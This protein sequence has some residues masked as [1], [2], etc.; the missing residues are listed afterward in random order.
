[1]LFLN[2]WLLPGL[3]AVLIPIIIHL[4]NRRSAKFMDWGA[5]QF[6][7]DSFTSRKSRIQLEEVLLMAT[8]CLLMALLALAVARPF[9][10]AGSV[11]TWVVVLP[12]VLGGFGCMA[13]WSVLRDD[14]KW[15]KRM[16]W[17]GT[18]A[19]VLA[20]AMIAG[21]S[22]LGKRFGGADRDVVIILDSSASMGIKREGRTNFEHALEEARTLIKGSQPG[23][24]FGIVLAGGAAEPMF[25][26]PVLSRQD[27]IQRLERLEP[28]GGS[29]YLPQALEAAVACLSRGTR[30]PKQI[31]IISDAQSLNWDLTNMGAWMELRG[32]MRTLPVPPQVVW[33]R[34]P[35]PES[36]RNVAI[37]RV[38]FPK[39]S[40]GTYQDT[41]IDVT[42]RNT[43]RE[44][45]TPTSV[46]LGVA[47]Q[48][49]LMPAGGQL[50][51]GASSVVRF[52]HRFEM[53]G[54]QS[55]TARLAVEDDL[56]ADN[57]A[58]VVVPVA[59]N[60]HI[61]VVDGNPAAQL[62]DR[63]AG[64]A[65]LGLTPDQATTM[66]PLQEMDKTRFA[67][68]TTVVDAPA[69]LRIENF[70]PYHAVILSDVVRLPTQVV[71]RLTRYVESGGGLLVAPG[72]RSQPDFYNHWTSSSGPFLPAKLAQWSG[73]A[74]GMDRRAALDSF[75]MEA[76]KGLADTRFSDLD[77]W[78]IGPYWTLSETRGA[79]VT[80]DARMDDGGALLVERRLGQGRVLLTSFP[81]DNTGGN[82]VSRQ[83]FV[84]LLHSLVYELAEAAAPE[85][86]LECA[87]N[88]TL[89]FSPSLAGSPTAQKT[90]GLRGEYFDTTISASRPDS[91]RIDPVID[92]AWTNRP[93][94]TTVKRPS[95]VKPTVGIRWTGSLVP[96]KSGA[97]LFSFEG[98]KLAS[99][100]IEGNLILTGTRKR[101]M[102]FDLTAGKRCDI[103]IE[104]NGQNEKDKAQLLWT[105]PGATETVIPSACLL[106]T[107]GDAAIAEL[108]EQLTVMDPAGK[109]RDITAE[110]HN[111]VVGLTVSGRPVPGLYRV[112]TT[113]T[114][115]N[116]LGD[117]ID[118]EGNLPF[119]I[120]TGID[121]S[122]IAALPGPAIVMV[123][124]FV[125]LMEAPTTQDALL[126]LSGRRFGQELWRI[127]AWAALVLI[128]AEIG[129]ARWIAGSRRSGQW[130]RVAFDDT[131]AAAS[132]MG[133][134]P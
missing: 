15:R 87:P 34:L 14:P 55:I 93:A 86:N 109:E 21:E 36:Y 57:T 32:L 35:F 46:I 75:R 95:W 13:A 101:R 71:D 58:T 132:L 42:I 134:K 4:L 117:L 33:R 65:A 2:I 94:K 78:V 28:G 41:L 81:L 73:P 54:V 45:V 72:A 67:M 22:V 3:L 105:E 100:W 114:L 89:T 37:E 59:R 98:G 23:T 43:G 24:A 12:L 48:S 125:D 123:R 38:S 92:L 82:L 88:V 63:A 29:L 115:R 84:P 11:F 10:P 83:A 80:I 64:F 26:A 31:V 66:V 62:L 68:K 16:F 126:A 9:I 27:L 97:H 104:Y 103:R 18:I 99:V 47:G 107:R 61:L 124:Q 118:P 60:L 17:F 1:M 111:G 30:G 56:A 90:S 106:P 76:I 127:L 39:S 91:I 44:A 121:E 131:A 19:L 110:M 53:P 133:R 108:N 128:I 70:S 122:D 129:I 120:R 40:V 77:S 116:V 102:S 130:K 49:Q 113:Y 52:H 7:E 8:R 69:I 119:T 50:A 5:M 112:R 25:P 51:P 85:L 20:A 6:L 96:R 74:G 79:D